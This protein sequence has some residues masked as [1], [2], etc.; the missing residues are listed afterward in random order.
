V[1][2]D[3]NYLTVAPGAA[4]LQPFALFIEHTPGWACGMTTR[5]QPKLAI[6]MRAAWSRTRHEFQFQRVHK[7][8]H[9]WLFSIAGLSS[10][11]RHA[12]S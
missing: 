8:F 7:G 3:F 1:D 11:E 10:P 5:M 12:P 9:K 2:L 4:H 6:V